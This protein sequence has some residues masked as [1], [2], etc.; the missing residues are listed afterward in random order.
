MA[1][2]DGNKQQLLER[3]QQMTVEHD[4]AAAVM[5]ASKASQRPATAFDRQPETIAAINSY[6]DSEC[7]GGGARLNVA[8]QGATP[9]GF[10][11]R[12]EVAGMALRPT[13]SATATVRS[14]AA[15]RRDD[16][17]VFGDSSA[18][19]QSPLVVSSAFQLKHGNV[20]HTG[21]ST[22]QRDHRNNYANGTPTKVRAFKVMDPRDP[23]STWP[24]TACI[25]VAN[26]PDNR[27]DWT[28]EAAVTQEFERFGVVFVKIRR[29]HQNMPFAFVQFT[30]DHDANNA[31]I[32]GKGTMILGRPCRTETVRANRTY[33]IYRYDDKD[34]TVEEANELLTPF[35]E[36]ETARFL[37]PKIQGEMR[38]PVTVKV[39]FKVFDQTQQ[40]LRAFRLNKTYKVEGYDFKKA[41]QARARNPDRVFI[42]NY[43]R[44]RRSVFMGDLPVNFTE[45]N[46]RALM[47]DVGDVVSVQTK[48]IEYH[49][50]LKR[51][52]FVEFTNA[53]LPDMAVERYNLNEINGQVIRVERRTDKRRTGFSTARFQINAFTNHG[54]SSIGGKPPSTPAREQRGALAIEGGPDSVRGTPTGRSEAGS[55]MEQ[56]VAQSPMN[57][58]PQSV[59]A[60][61]Q[62]P[63]GLGF[64]QAPVQG[65]MQYPMAPPPV[66]HAM[67]GQHQ[68]VPPMPAAMQ[69][70]P[71]MALPM[72]MQMMQQSPVQMPQQFGTPVHSPNVGF[73]S[74]MG[75]PFSQGPMSQGPGSSYGFMTPQQSPLP[76]W[77]YG[78]GTPLWTP[79]HINPANYMG[80]HTSP[81]AASRTADSV[82]EAAPARV[83]AH[84][85]TQ[86]E[87]APSEL[88]DDEEVE[89]AAN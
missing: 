84:E 16:D 57:Q 82:A 47:E 81:A 60:Y 28:L 53:T 15:A 24:T 4:R 27:D 25:F 61:S 51:I 80:A 70:G 71:Q 50:E 59:Q 26:L 74:Q 10:T 1:S 35:G 41:M 76:F 12:A 67:A 8:S 30:N 69:M 48:T 72:Q 20:Q 63:A 32:T 49:R 68:M 85:T 77:G 62:Q 19:T 23:Q 37:D 13:S 65:P 88:Y 44:D 18:Q 83:K 36:L 46:I 58:A 7:G 52:A 56:A 89:T 40:V 78:T 17:D 3:L 43:D 86:S 6:E 66:P 73:N 75:S 22:G 21:P 29:D 55:H 2:S 34:M 11:R 31:R 14:N 42:D 87:P 79:F 33:I 64:H 9:S 54:G 38:L 45:G 39:Q 5:A